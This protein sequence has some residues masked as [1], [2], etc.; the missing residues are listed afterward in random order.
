VPGKSRQHKSEKRRKELNRQ[1]RQ[2]EKRERRSE[3][4]GEPGGGPPIDWG[5]AGTGVPPTGD[6]TPEAP[7]AP[8]GDRSGV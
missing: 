6:P 2:K 7:P 5:E 3:Q 4:K 1:A 8:P